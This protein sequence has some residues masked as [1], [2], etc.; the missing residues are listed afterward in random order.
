MR[1]VLKV[2]VAL[3]ALSLFFP[4]FSA[5]LYPF[6]LNLKDNKIFEGEFTCDKSYFPPYPVCYKP[7]EEDIE[8]YKKEHG[9]R[10][11]LPWPGFYPN[12]W[13]CDRNGYWG[14]SICTDKPTERIPDEKEVCLIFDINLLKKKNLVDESDERYKKYQEIYEE[15]V[16]KKGKDVPN[17]FNLGV[18]KKLEEHAFIGF[19]HNLGFKCNLKAWSDI[20]KGKEA[21]CLGGHS[22]KCTKD[23]YIAVDLCTEGCDEATGRCK[24]YKSE[25]KKVEKDSSVPKDCEATVIKD[26]SYSH[27]GESCHGEEI[28]IYGK[29][30]CRLE[31]F[32]RMVKMGSNSVRGEFVA[33][34]FCKSDVNARAIK[35]V[36]ERGLGYFLL[37]DYEKRATKPSIIFCSE[38]EEAALLLL[39]YPEVYCELT[40]TESGFKPLCSEEDVNK[41][42]IEI[43]QKPV[44]ELIGCEV[45]KANF[46]KE[47]S[48]YGS[49]WVGFKDKSALSKYHVNSLLLFD[50]NTIEYVK[51]VDAPKG[52][53]Y[54][55]IL[56][57]KKAFTVGKGAFVTMR[58]DEST[59]LIL[60]F[61][62]KGKYV[63]EVGKMLFD[64]IPKDVICKKQVT[65]TID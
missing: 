14:I 28:F 27:L 50:I 11:L 20:S 54:I 31:Y 59:P 13:I 42:V 10:K 34:D 1:A 53:N 23:G 45:S 51:L 19:Y 46:Y 26:C 49:L 35:S 3:L 40:R 32:R 36:I 44:S 12:S 60:Q 16:K 47:G 33:E 5:D 63:I 8:S 29:P 52:A 24:E 22:V 37:I 39:L 58:I 30:E 6:Y 25:L 7:S 55:T 57:G 4:A 17:P 43:L 21:I 62:E 61:P 65:I 18:C 9:E 15:L 2:M 64:A 41:T 56:R 48:L 38:R